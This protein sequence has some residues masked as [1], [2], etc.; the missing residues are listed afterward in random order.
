MNNL[1]LVD[2]KLVTIDD[3]S[4]FEAQIDSVIEA[5]RANRQEINRLGLSCI[6]CLTE[7]DERQNELN[8]KGA[9]EQLVG[10]FT[11]NNRKVERKISENRVNAQYLAQ[12]TLKKLAEQNL[13]SFDLLVAVNNKLNFHVKQINNEIENIYQGLNKFFKRYQSQMIQIEVRQDKVERNLNLL[14]WSSSIEY[15]MFNDLPY[16][17]LDPLS[18]TV[19]V[20]R[21]F[22]EITK[23]EWSFSD[24]ILIKSVLLQLSLTPGDTINLWDSILI[25]QDSDALRMKL[26]GNTEP[27]ITDSVTG[28]GLIILESMYKLSRFRN[29]DKYQVSAC[30]EILRA[31]NVNVS[32]GE[33]VNALSRSYINTVNKINIDVGISYFNF[34]FELLFNLKEGA[35]FITTR[36]NLLLAAK[37][38]VEKTESVGT[39]ESSLEAEEEYLDL[40]TIARAYL[41]Y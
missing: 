12:Q 2:E 28:N 39:A 9:I 15:Q 40:D 1:Q 41:D 29:E 18:K 26:L 13:L 17:E 16:L 25:V 32:T 34:V 20:A 36:E 23:G 35:Q 22:Y 21:D 19:C 4:D 6:A 5:H 27:V 33:L 3:R 7:A 24:L 11:G 8:N 38:D 14:T 30:N 37:D 10:L 31:K